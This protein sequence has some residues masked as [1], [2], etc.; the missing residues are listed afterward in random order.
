MKRL[1]VFFS[2]NGNSNNAFPFDPGDDT[3]TL[4]GQTLHK[5]TR[6]AVWGELPSAQRKEI[7]S[8]WAADLWNFGAKTEIEKVGAALYAQKPYPE[9]DQ[10]H[11][12]NE[13]ERWA[14]EYLRSKQG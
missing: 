8:G 7:A 9:H 13:V 11:Y 14:T 2:G 12:L 6:N 10:T 3:T 4:M 1:I 5:N